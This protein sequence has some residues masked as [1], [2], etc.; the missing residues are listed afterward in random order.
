MI[1]HF[2]STLLSS[3]VLNCCSR[4]FLMSVARS[5]IFVTFCPVTALVKMSGAQGTKVNSREIRGASAS[6]VKASLPST[7]S[8]L[9][10]TST[11]PFPA[12]FMSPASFWSICALSSL[13]SMSS[14]QTSDSSIAARVRRTENFSIPCSCLPL[15]RTP[16]VSRSSIVWLL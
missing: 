5:N 6:L 10:T 9:L 2:C 1:T 11:R 4:R 3:D 14:K 15:R 12:S 13:T 7:A 8:H 16:A